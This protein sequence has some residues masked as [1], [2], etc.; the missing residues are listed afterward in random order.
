MAQS[1]AVAPLG[2]GGA[3]SVPVDHPLALVLAGCA[4]LGMGVWAIRAR[5][6]AVVRGLGLLAAGAVLAVATGYN[7]GAWAT[8]PVV[9]QLVSWLSPQGGTQPI[10]VVPRPLAPSL[11]A[12][13]APVQFTNGSGVALKITAITPPATVG[14]CFPNGVPGTLPSTPLPGTPAPCAVGNTLQNQQSCVVDVA[15]MCAQVATSQV[16]ML[17]VSPA[18]LTLIAGAFAQSTI[19]VTNTSALLT[20]TGLTMQTSAPS[21]TISSN[22][23]AAALAPG[24]SCTI[25]LTPSASAHAVENVVIHGTN[26]NTVM[27]DVTTQQAPAPTLTSVNPPSMQAGTLTTVTLTGT[28]LSSATSVTFGGVPVGFSVTNDTTIIVTTAGNDLPLGAEVVEVTTLGG[29]ATL[30]GGFVVLN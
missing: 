5:V 27:V 6:G 16:A 1:I 20:A 9:T 10:P 30:V 2:A 21:F 22:T 18:S 12:D 19:T 15:G 7:P 29:S 17:Q 26:T 23:C 13:F 4:V 11:P 28:G 24:S 3:A 8:P 14:A 25:G